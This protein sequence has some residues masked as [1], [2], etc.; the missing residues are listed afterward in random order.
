[1]PR[2]FPL[3]KPLVART[4]SWWRL[5][6]VLA[7][8]FSLQGLGA[9]FAGLPGLIAATGFYFVLRKF[10]QRRGKSFQKAGLK[11]L[12]EERYSEA[13]DMFQAGYEYF[14]ERRWMDRYRAISMLDH[15][16]MD[17]R[18]IMLGNTAMSLA[19]AGER[20]RAIELYQRCL[21]LYPES[22]LAK[23]ALRLLTANAGQ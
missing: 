23:P 7:V 10:L 4:S 11:L 14:S 12:A 2:R 5:C 15:S 17:W 3:S 18:E 13:A 22:R 20:K 9:Y 1:M 19:M 6:V 21:E 16:G 8:L